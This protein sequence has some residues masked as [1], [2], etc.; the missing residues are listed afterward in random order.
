[1]PKVTKDKPAPQITSSAWIVMSCNQ[2]KGMD[3]YITVLRNEEGDYHK[4][5]GGTHYKRGITVTVE[6]IVWENGHPDAFIVG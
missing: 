5:W 2:P 4:A 1:M 3:D 6:T